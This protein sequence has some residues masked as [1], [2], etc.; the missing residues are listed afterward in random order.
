M[1]Y[2]VVEEPA[3]STSPLQSHTA[4]AAIIDI[5]A[6][7]I[8]ALDAQFRIV[9]FNRGAEQIF[10]W[11]E[12]E[13]LGQPL[14]RLLPMAA[15]SVHRTHLR[16]FADGQ[17]DARQMAERRLISGV[18]RSG[19]SFPAEA[20]IARAVVDG[21]L[22][23]MV[24]L[25]DASE[26]R[27]REER[28]RLLGTAGW[29]LASSLDVDSTMATITELPV[30]MLAD[31]SVLD[32]VAPEGHW[33]RVAATHR[34]PGRQDEVTGL[35]ARHA[36]LAS[37]D[38]AVW[39]VARLVHEPQALAVTD[40]AAWQQTNCGDAASRARV[41]GLGA[42]AVLVVPL[43]AGSRAL[44]VLHLVRT[45]E[46]A[47]F[48]PDE[49]QVADQYGSLAALA[50]ENARLY[51]EARQA[52]R[53]RDEMLAIVS[54][55]LRNPVNAIVLLTGAALERPGQA[56][57]L[58]DR[59]E[60][61]HVRAAAR[62]ANGLIQDL[63]DVTRISAGRL[64]I[65]Q[66]PV[67]LDDL[68]E[69]IANQF[70]PTMADAGLHFDRTIDREVPPLPLDRIRMGQVLS[71]LLANAVRFTPEGG[72][73]TLTLMARAN[74]VVMQ[75]SDTGPGIA[76]EDLPRLFERYW[77]APRL[78]RAGSGLGLYIVKGI[79]EAHGGTVEVTST[80]GVG[81]TFTVTLPMPE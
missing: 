70:L 71:N 61:E 76:A 79:V 18:R 57:T 68:V 48:L 8:I 51:H 62:Q 56:A 38:Q 17:V 77:Q 34:D 65:E 6:D 64:R 78:L 23:V 69:E 37:F 43:R 29:V 24:V 7:A 39:G 80:V 2:P 5:A 46:G 1:A 54:H 72:R 75:V 21:E 74:E 20:S 26:R 16:T 59:T 25:R 81:S 35:L 14:D 50:L 28:Q 49:I 45:G 52:V 63:Q 12:A 27:Q 53:E 11:S 10:E 30:P 40:V 42:T 31:W 3:V 36:S 66:R 13:M 60:V 55:D 22:T 32:L 44:G 9:R 19:E 47:R 58:L 33:R 4:L 67:L 15:R 41:E 73:V